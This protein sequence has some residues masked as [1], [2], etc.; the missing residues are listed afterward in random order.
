[1]CA[2]TRKFMR[3][4]THRFVISLLSLDMLPRSYFIHSD[5]GNKLMSKGFENAKNMKSRDIINIPSYYI[6]FG[7]DSL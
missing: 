1:M 2:I 3:S 5:C 4:W 6:L 7:L